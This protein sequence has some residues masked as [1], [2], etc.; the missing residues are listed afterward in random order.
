VFEKSHNISF[1][2]TEIGMSEDNLSNGYQD[3]VYLTA[4]NDNQSNLQ[5]THAIKLREN[6]ESLSANGTI[7]K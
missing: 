4:M 3:T 6:I 2:I 5:L 7:L 1:E